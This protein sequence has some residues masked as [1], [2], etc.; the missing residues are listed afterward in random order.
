MQSQQHERLYEAVWKKLGSWRRF[1]IAVDGRDGAGKS[2]TARYL[3]WQLGVPCIETD[4]FKYKRSQKLA[5]RLSALRE[6]IQQRLEEGRPV[7][8]E[9]LVLLETLAQLGISP[10]FHVY[11]INSETE[12]SFCWR[13][14]FEGYERSRCP[15]ERADFVFS[16]DGSE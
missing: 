1:L 10:D 6:P 8:V 15:L 5:Y 12:G 4:F 9:G 16:H 11:V 3:S 14:H 13:E 7:V 2:T